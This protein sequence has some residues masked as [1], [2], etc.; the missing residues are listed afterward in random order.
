M[1]STK[2]TQQTLCDYGKAVIEIEARVVINL[3][4]KIDQHFAKAC[5]RLLACEGR[6]ILTG[7]GKS[8]HIAR[9]LAATFASTG[10]PA[11]FVH[12]AEA[13]HGDLGMVTRKDVVIALSHSGETNEILHML[14]LIKRF[15][16]PLISLTSNPYSTLAKASDIHLNIHAEEEACPLGLAPTSSTTATLVM[17][18]AL[19]IT[20]LQAR[21]FTSDDFALYHP[22]GR[23]GRRLLLSV[24]D[25]MRI[26]NAIP[27]VKED[28]LLSQA[29]IEMTQKNLGMTAIVDDQNRLKGIY[30][31]GDLRRTLNKNIAINTTCVAEVMTKSPKT[32]TKDKL[33]MEALHLMETYKI[34]SL[35]VVCP[36][37]QTLE[38]IIHMHDLLTAGLT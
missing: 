11:F 30:T 37:S 14:P 22:G 23:L 25:V 28:A 27:T 24:E 33:A 31:D 20:L 5:E 35:T 4:D 9:K 29:L 15:N 2:T 17:G 12:A 34:T 19:A 36:L 7:V 6:I 10:T 1:I 8:G 13:S 18:D 16:L 32:I 38:G 21:G 3:K 26:S